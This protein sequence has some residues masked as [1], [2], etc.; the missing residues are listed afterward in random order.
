[1]MKKRI[2][3]AFLCIALL[4]TI[5]STGAVAMSD[6]YSGASDWAVLELDKAAEYGLITE[7]FLF[8]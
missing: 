2:M 6:D 7:P 1:M 5:S 3:T 4:F 8:W